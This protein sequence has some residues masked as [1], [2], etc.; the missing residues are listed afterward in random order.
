MRPLQ[1][2]LSIYS[3]FGFERMPV[4]VVYCFH[5]PEGVEKLDKKLGLCEMA[6]EVQETGKAFYFTGEEE[7]CIGK[8]F[9][10]MA[11]ELPHRSDGGLLGVKFQLFKEGHDNLRHRTFVPLM[12]TGSVNYV[13]FSPLDKLQYEPDIL[14]IVADTHQAAILMRAMIYSTG[15][16]YESRATIVGQCSSLF[17]YP[18]LNGKINYITNRN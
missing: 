15:E 1:T 8:R 11:G 3:K 18:Y 7:N 4:G 12:D 5:K 9:M 2:D 17:I 6:K 14:F 16:M 13:I 10:G